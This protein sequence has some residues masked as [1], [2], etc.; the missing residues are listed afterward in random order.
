MKW[1]FIGL[2]IIGGLFT[3]AWYGAKEPEQTRAQ[4]RTYGLVALAIW[5]TALILANTLL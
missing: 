1:L 2:F 3:N 4:K 5:A